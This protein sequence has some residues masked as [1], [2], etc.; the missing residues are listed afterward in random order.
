M[1]IDARFLE[2]ARNPFRRGALLT[3]EDLAAR[4]S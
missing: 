2:H 3:P 4:L 1:I